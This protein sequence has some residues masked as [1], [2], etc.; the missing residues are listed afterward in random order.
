[1]PDSPTST[2]LRL[3]LRRSL[4]LSVA[5]LLALVLL[6][7]T[8]TVT[9]DAAPVRPAKAKRLKQALDSAIAQTKAPGVIAGVWVGNRGWTAVRGSTVRGRTIRP[10][11][12][13]HTRIGSVTKT[14]TGTLI[15]KLVDRGKLRLDDTI[16]RWFPAVPLA[17]QITI[18][19]LG[20][21]SS[22]IN[23]YTANQS[24]VN[25]YLTHPRTVWN[26]LTLIAGGVDLPRKFAPG[27]GFFYSN[28]NFVM[29][30][31]IVEMV[32][33]NPIAQVMRRR[34]FKPLKMRQTSYPYSLALPKPFWNG[35]TDQGATT[36]NPVLNS[37]HWSP[38]FASSAGQI[39]STLG[40]MRRYTKALG[41]GSMLKPS[42][43]R[44]RLVP[45][46]FSMAGGRQ[47]DFAI[48]KDHGWLTHVGEVP[49]YNTQIAYLPKKKATIVVLTNT[50]ISNSDGSS[51][52]PSLVSPLAAVVAPNHV[53]SGTS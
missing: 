4:L 43:Q 30:G 39:V 18:S 15:L 50:D 25:R 17:D 20:T 38:T 11:R 2:D 14:F 45:N 24:I 29:L 1:M 47:Y 3:A 7:T 51:P 19:D 13:D 35:Y 12:S 9:T 49:G 46:P 53:P 26:P 42:T 48:G 10:T 5:G 41:N 21:M 52:A 28:T 33:G 6:G 23:T 31:R 32:T 8:V 37:T 44:A 40:D 34:I 36:A 27:Q 16:D 22:G